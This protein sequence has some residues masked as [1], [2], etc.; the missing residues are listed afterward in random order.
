[1]LLRLPE[2][3]HD[4]Q[5]SRDN[6]RGLQD[7]DKHRGL[8]DIDRNTNEIR[9]ETVEMGGN[10]RCLAEDL[11]HKALRSSICPYLFLST[12]K[13]LI[14]SFC[15]SLRLVDQGTGKVPDEHCISLNLY[16]TEVLSTFCGEVKIVHSRLFM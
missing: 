10:L 4:N 16:C 7:I 12:G 14:T 8:Q 5:R 6:H 11:K 3:L 15:R 2:G 9:K 13:W 1:M